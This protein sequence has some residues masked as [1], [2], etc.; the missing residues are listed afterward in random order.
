M[1]LNKISTLQK[2]LLCWECYMIIPK[3]KRKVLEE[4]MRPDKRVNPCKQ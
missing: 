2:L 1:A 4:I 3:E